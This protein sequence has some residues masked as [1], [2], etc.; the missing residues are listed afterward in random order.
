MANLLDGFL[1]Q[2]ATGDTV[3]DFKHASRLFVDNNYGLSPKYD[4]L[5][6]VYFDV[7]Q[8]SGMPRDPRVEA[9]MLVKDV[10]LPA[11]QFDTQTVNNYNRPE[12]IQTKARYQEVSMTFHDDQS[13]VVRSLL[14]DY[15]R[16]YYTDMNDAF[17]TNSQVSGNQINDVFKRNSKYSSGSRTKLNQFGYTPRNTNL[18][19][20]PAYF[21]AIRIYSLHKKHF[22]EYILVNPTITNYSHGRHSASSNGTLDIS[23]TVSYTT[24]LYSSGYIIPD[25]TVSGFGILHYD[26]SPS[27]LTPAGGGTNSITG[28]GGILNAIDN[29]LGD[30]RDGNFAGAAFNTFRA[31]QKNKNVDLKGLA[32]SELI[33]AVKDIANQKNP[34]DRFFIPSAGGVFDGGINAVT[35]KAK[36]IFNS[37]AGKTPGAS[38]GSVTSNGASVNLTPVNFIQAESLK[39]PISGTPSVA[40]GINLLGTNLTESG[41]IAGANLNKTLDLAKTSVPGAV[42]AISQQTAPVFS[43]FAGAISQIAKD[44]EEKAQSVADQAFRSSTGATE[45]SSGQLES[46]ITKFST[47]TNNIVGQASNALKQTPFGDSIVQA[48]GPDGLNNAQSAI[49]LASKE[50]SKFIKDGNAQKLVDSLRLNGFSTN[51]APGSTS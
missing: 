16:H 25:N 43:G 6:H 41:S 12:V 39:T 22:S 7:S 4:W 40:S 19:G 15:F 46:A 18:F 2:L 23:M 50:A 21:D 33:T 27:P 38:S 37:V 1:K 5:Y 45:I 47:G 51:P 28:P 13:N 8:N 9:G 17:Q 30:A 31:I 44:M 29:V 26:Q 36:D 24:V 49:D 3:K 11:I 34:T 32:K 10:Q 42:E 14:E 48:I 35:G 20:S